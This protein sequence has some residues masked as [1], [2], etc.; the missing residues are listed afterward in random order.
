MARHPSPYDLLVVVPSESTPGDYYEI[1]R[2]RVTQALGCSC[3]SF[4]M[5]PTC[6]QCG[7][8]LQRRHLEDRTAYDCT[9]CA[10]R[11]VAKSCKHLRHFVAGAGKPAPV[12]V[13]EAMLS[14]VAAR[15]TARRGAG[16]TATM[17]QPVALDAPVRVVIF[18]DDE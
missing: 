17:R 16:I 18:P 2:H 9:R 10:L 14:A 7:K 6:P 4:K 11:D 8:V 13:A 3:T 15:R 1:K 5:A 12:A